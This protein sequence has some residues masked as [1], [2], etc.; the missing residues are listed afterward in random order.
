MSEPIDP[1][2]QSNYDR[3][4][5]E[6]RGL[7][8][9]RDALRAD[10]ERVTKEHDECVKDYG[11]ECDIRDKTEKERDAMRADLER[12]TR[13]RDEATAQSTTLLSRAHKAE[14][15]YRSIEHR[16]AG[17]WSAASGWVDV[18]RR[19]GVHVPIVTGD[20]K[21]NIVTVLN[22]AC[23]AAQGKEYVA[24]GETLKLR[25]ERDAALA[26]AEA[27]RDASGL[28]GSHGGIEGD[29]SSV[30][31][32]HVK[33]HIEAV[34]KER[35][36]AQADLALCD[37]HYQSLG[38]DYVA[39][40]A[41]KERDEALVLLTAACLKTPEGTLLAG[42]KAAIRA[43]DSAE[44][45]RDESNKAMYTAEARAERLAGALRE[46][47]RFIV[48][49]GDPY[50][51]PLIDAALADAPKARGVLLSVE[52]ALFADRYLRWLAEP[53]AGKVQARGNE[54][55]D[56]IRARLSALAPEND[57]GEKGART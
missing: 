53:S 32:E 18:L 11:Q 19:M 38:R 7:Q 34:E 50:A 28:V 5:S 35:D 2:R 40:T 31:P 49:A 57:A 13:E 6:V 14:I 15:A 39:R 4:L 48:L 46:L 23:A 47:R 3:L 16:F 42:V 54:I 30:K 8:D 24:Y 20:D 41:E 55:A 17:I 36:E 26:I 27:F 12:V 44:I 51:R 56:A 10:L 43:R 1:L 37:K 33:A 22:A 21:S 52:E 9:D 45:V 29:P 25:K